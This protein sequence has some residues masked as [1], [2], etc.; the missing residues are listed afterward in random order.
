MSKGFTHE[1]GYEGATNI[2]LTPKPIIDDLGPFDLDPCAAPEP[3][4][5]PTAARHIVEAEDGLSQPWA[6]FVFLNPPYGPHM[7]GWLERM[8]AHADGG[9]AFTFA[10]TETRAFFKSVW[11]ASSGLLFVKGRVRFCRPD[12]KPAL[13]AAAPS[14]LIAYGDEAMRR[15]SRSRIEG[16]LVVQAA[17]ILL[18]PG[19]GRPPKT[20]REAIN[21]ALE[22]R[23]QMHLRDI[24]RA[25]E[26]TQRAQAA[27]ASGV[28]WRE[29][30]RR[31][32]QEH[33]RP[34]ERGVWATAGA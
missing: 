5:W 16:H 13:A 4:P 2:W 29:K 33:F 14:V 17:A 25:V 15:L 24:Y 12:G 22:G 30:V 1:R 28:K 23:G 7:P 34:V 9:I 27:A 8:A 10:R 3:R 31:V 6:G 32:L 19:G 18:G 11:E 21:Q 20:W 26:P